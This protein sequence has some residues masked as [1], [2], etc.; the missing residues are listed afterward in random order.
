MLEVR[1]FFDR[2]TVRSRINTEDGQLHKIG[3]PAV[4]EYFVDGSIMLEEWYFKGKYHN[5]NGPAYIKHFRNN[6]CTEIQYWLWGEHIW[7]QEIIDFLEEYPQDC[8]ENK[9]LYKL[10][11]G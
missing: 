1:Y 5:S 4:I 11:F 10:T 3:G 7:E 6:P 8:I 9:V 2:T